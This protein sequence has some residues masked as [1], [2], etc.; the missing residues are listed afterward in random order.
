M[1]VNRLYKRLHEVRE[2]NSLIR[3]E[4]KS[5]RRKDNKVD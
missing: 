1:S 5:R 4:L 3:K 2:L